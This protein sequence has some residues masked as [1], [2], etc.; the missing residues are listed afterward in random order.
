MSFSERN[1][2]SLAVDNVQSQIDQYD[3]KVITGDIDS[4]SIA[5]IGNTLINYGLSSA[6]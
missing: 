4:N 1:P 2:H 6:G 3:S 5:G